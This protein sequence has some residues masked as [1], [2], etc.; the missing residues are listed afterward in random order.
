[1]FEGVFRAVTTISI[2]RVCGSISLCRLNNRCLKTGSR[3]AFTLRGFPDQAAAAELH[4]RVCGLHCVKFHM[5]LRTKY[6]LALLPAILTVGWWQMA[7]WA[8][9]HFGCEGNL[10]SLQP[11]FAGGV[12]ILPAL[13]FGLFWCQL[14][15]WICAPISLWLLIEVGGRHIGSYRKQHEI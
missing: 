5:R 13:G 2:G 1:M 3:Q 4:R 11:C 7:V 6:F 8:Y 15:A 10:K 9:G 12:N 14:L